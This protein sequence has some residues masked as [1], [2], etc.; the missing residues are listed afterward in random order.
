MDLTSG[1]AGIIGLAALAASTTKKIVDS[2]KEIK[3]LPQDLHQRI[4]LLNHLRQLLQNLQQRL[5]ADQSQIEA[6]V[7]LTL[8]KSHLESC[9]ESLRVLS[10]ILGG[11]A[12]SINDPNWTKAGGA[13]LKAVLR[14]KEVGKHFQYVRDGIDFLM[15]CQSIST[16][17]SVCSSYYG[18]FIDSV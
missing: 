12:L 1:I 3:D 11:Q 15:L 9:L 5:I 10:Q 8:L 16:E 7:D 6:A 2:I 18:F 13:R 4:Q 14:S 17:Y